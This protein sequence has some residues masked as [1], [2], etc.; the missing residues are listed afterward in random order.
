MSFSISID[1]DIFE[2]ATLRS[3]CA[4]QIISLISTLCQ[5]KK[6]GGVMLGCEVFCGA[7]HGVELLLQDSQKLLSH[8]QPS[9]IQS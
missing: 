6:E 1:S 2:E 3:R 9:E 4:E 7:M 8:T 5:D